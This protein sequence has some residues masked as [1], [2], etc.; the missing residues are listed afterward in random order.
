LKWTALRFVF[1]GKSIKDSKCPAQLCMI[2]F[3]QINCICY[4]GK[5]GLEQ[6]NLIGFEP[7]D[8]DSKNV[9][10]IED[11]QADTDCV[12]SRQEGI[13]RL[14]A[15]EKHINK[16]GLKQPWVRLIVAKSRGNK[17]W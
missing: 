16:L 6:C 3:D 10:K 15:I 9:P 12:I 4:S 8:R 5:L 11:V 17:E 2:D 1:D 13:Q 7:C 14:D